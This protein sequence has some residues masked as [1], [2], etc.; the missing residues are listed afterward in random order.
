VIS[1]ISQANIAQLT[2]SPRPTVDSKEVLAERLAKALANGGAYED[3]AL[4]EVTIIDYSKLPKPIEQFGEVRHG[5]YTEAGRSMETIKKELGKIEAMIAKRRPDLAGGWDAKLVDGKF[6][7]TG[8][9]A[10]DA[11]WLET[12]LNANTALKGAA[13]AFIATTVSHLE[14]SSDN[15]PRVDFS[16]VTRKMESFDFHG[17]RAQLEDKLSFR[18]LLS[19]S[20]D[21]IDS[22]RITMEA[23]D[24][25][26]SGLAVAAHMLT[27]NNPP[28]EHKGAFFTTSYDG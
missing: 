1:S 14:V 23:A 21:V 4:G 28:L 27:P 6:K 10:D 13:E 9:D 12:K 18:A 24:R 19:Q 20:D 2:S 16:Y 25:G 5:Q 26:M 8:L 22:K 15:L 17:V 11:K 3:P 7:V